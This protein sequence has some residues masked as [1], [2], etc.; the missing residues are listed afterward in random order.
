M[1]L[2]IDFENT[3]SKAL[4][5]I[6]LLTESDVVYICAC[7]GTGK[8]TFDEMVKLQN[9]RPQVKFIK[10]F[11][12]GKDGVDKWI[13]KNA[14]RVNELHR[15]FIISHDKVYD[16]LQTIGYDNIFR[17]PNNIH[18]VMA[19]NK[20]HLNLVTD[21]ID[22]IYKKYLEENTTEVNSVN[23][24]GIDEEVALTID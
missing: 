12:T 6:E 21:E 13:M 2:F 16:K 10:V 9:A 5:G 8:F 14:S 18:D 1:I 11:D 15:V 23:I 20:Q 22:L 17:V 7:E 19:L 24:K 4:E 3:G